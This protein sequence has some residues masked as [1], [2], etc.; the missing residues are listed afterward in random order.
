MTNVTIGDPPHWPSY[1][2]PFP[3]P[4][5]MPYNH[6]SVGNCPHCGMLHS[7]TCPRIKSIEYFQ[8]GITVKKIEFKE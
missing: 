6:V 1:S 8:D 3:G 2:Y 5:T 4:S 7:T